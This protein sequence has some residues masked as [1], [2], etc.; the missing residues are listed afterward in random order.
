MHRELKIGSFAIFL[1]A[2]I[3]KR[4][5]KK[6][7]ADYKKLIMVSFIND[8]SLKN[9]QHFHHI[10]KKILIARSKNAKT[11]AEREEEAELERLVKS[12]A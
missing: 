11:A 7:R 5:I 3:L 8:F 1:F 6:F 10:L 4:K 12:L 9:L 2:I